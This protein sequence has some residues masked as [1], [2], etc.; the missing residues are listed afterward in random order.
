MGSSRAR[1]RVYARLYFKVGVRSGRLAGV[2][3]RCAKNTLIPDFVRDKRK[4]VVD[5]LKGE[6]WEEWG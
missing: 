3:A 1:A 6:V 5:G 2:R 4:G